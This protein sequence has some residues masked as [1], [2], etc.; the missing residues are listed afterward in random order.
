ML[1]DLEHLSDPPAS[2]RIRTSRRGLLSAAAEA[3]EEQRRLRQGVPSYV[4]EDIAAYDDR[5]FDALRPAVNRKAKI[6]LENAVVYAETS[7]A[8][9]PI[10]LFDSA[11]PAL[12]IFNQFNGRQIMAEVFVKVQA[13]T[14]WDEAETRRIVRAVFLKLCEARVCEPG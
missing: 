3:A 2:I 5:Q 9:D 6:S 8:V 10:P 14:G 13:C 11:S 4:I 7:A 1:I 12:F